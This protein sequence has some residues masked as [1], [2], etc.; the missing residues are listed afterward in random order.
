MHTVIA[1]RLVALTI[2]FVLQHTSLVGHAE[3]TVRPEVFCN[4]TD[5]TN[6]IAYNIP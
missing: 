3:T 4:K 6:K 2:P 5:D 1:K